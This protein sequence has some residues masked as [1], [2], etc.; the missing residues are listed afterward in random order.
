MF[1]IPFLTFSIPY[2]EKVS[3]SFPLFGKEGL[4]EFYKS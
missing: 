1:I 3:L 4:G 2:L